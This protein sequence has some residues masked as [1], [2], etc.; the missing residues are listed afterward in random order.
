ADAFGEGG[1]RLVLVVLLVTGAAGSLAQWPAARRADARWREFVGALET[2][3]VTHCYTDFY[4]AAK[5]DML[6]EERVVCAADLGPTT[7]EYFHDYPVRV[8]AAPRA[9]L[10]AVNPT[11]ADKIG[12]RLER[13]GVAHERYDLMKPVLV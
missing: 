10:I 2:L 8:A 13:L 5:I 11:A 1:R 7:T 12:H 9:A 4:L 6:S 3:G